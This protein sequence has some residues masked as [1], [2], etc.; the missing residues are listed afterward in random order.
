PVVDPKKQRRPTLISKQ[1]T[2]VIARAKGRYQVLYALLGGSGLRIG[3]ALAIKLDDYSEDHTTISS[4][5][6]TIHVRK[7]IWNGKEQKP[8]TDNAI[9]SVDIPATLATFLKSFAADRSSGFLF[10]TETGLPLG[11][12]EEHTSELQSPY[13]LVCRLL[14][15]KKNIMDILVHELYELSLFMI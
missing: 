8:K 5:C 3:E 1:V 6:K 15:E 9:R 2:D 13:D 4:D 10:Q 11:R 7:S 12:S 14:L